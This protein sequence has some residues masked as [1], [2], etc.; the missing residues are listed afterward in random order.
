[1]E[2]ADEKKIKGKKLA[3]LQEALKAVRTLDR[4]RAKYPNVVPFISDHSM[5]SLIGA[6]EEEKAALSDR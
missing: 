4:L 3:D 5:V 6:I 2:R 1:M